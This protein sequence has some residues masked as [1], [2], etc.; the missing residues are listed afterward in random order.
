MSSATAEQLQREV[1]AEFGAQL[2]AWRSSY[3]GR[4]HE[5]LTR[6]WLL[7]LEREQIVTVAY[8]RDIIEA[9]L[10]HMP[11][12]EETRKV[13]ARAV[14]WAWRDEEM[15]A[16]YMRG[17]LLR[18]AVPTD[19]ARAWM[20]QVEGRIAGWTSSRQHHIRWAE[21]PA[22]RALAEALELAGVMA[23][24]IPGPARKALHFSTFSDFCCFNVAA[25]RTAGMGWARIAELAAEHPELGVA[26]D[27]ID[28]F[29]AIAADEERHAQ[30]F[31]IFA[32][33]FA[34][35]DRL[36]PGVDA[37]ALERELEGVGQRFVALPRRDAP[38]WRNPL[39]KGAPVL[40][41]Q[42]RGPGD[43]PRAL[44]AL[45]DAL[46]LPAD[47]TGQHVAI[48]TTFMM[49]TDRRDP[50]PGISVP[51]LKALGAWLHRRGAVVTVLD[52]ANIFDRYHARR[53]VAEVAAYLDL[54]S[55]HYAVVDADDVQVEHH[56]L[57]GLELHTIA[58]PWRDAHLRILLGK[59][60]GHPTS[61]AALTMEVAE[62]L[63][64]RNESRQFGDRR[65]D[66]ELVTAM[67]L[68]GF[69]P[70]L[71]LLDA[72]EH[73]PDGLM[74]V[75]GNATPK[76]P[77]RLYASRDAV[78]LDIVAG[79]HLGATDGALPLVEL[80]RDWFGDPSDRLTVDGPDTPIEGWTAPDATARTA[81]LSRLARPVY[82]HSSAHGALFL[83]DFDE[84][85]FPPLHR[86]SPGV[87]FARQLVRAVVAAPTSGA[88]LPTRWLPTAAGP[89]RIA[90]AGAG[91]PLVLLHGYP[92]TLQL[93]VN[94]HPALAAHFTVTAF[95]W[96]GQGYSARW[97]GAAA[98]LHR[99]LQLATI[100]DALGLNRPHLV[101]TDMG[102]HPALALAATQPHR[103]GRVAIMNALLFGD[104]PTSLEIGLMRRAGLNRL[105]FE[106]A[107]PLVYLQCKRTFLSP[108]DRR[109]WPTA[110][111]HDFERALSRPAVRTFLSDLCA[112][113]EAALPDLPALYWRLDTP[114]LALWA[115]RDAHFPVAQAERF[116]QLV[117]S[118]RLRVLAAAHHWMA[119]SRAADLA[120]HL[121]PFL[122]E[123]P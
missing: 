79:C 74:G 100:L 39:G 70:D 65:A 16:L 43:G 8:R 90:Q 120:Q 63:G 94:L 17:V 99:A 103:V 37:A 13:V 7:A 109:A 2:D 53:S 91:P 101:A 76:H 47:L 33:R 34:E 12:D 52:S 73:V 106:R 71:A 69:A 102:V 3:V 96:P 123:T 122:Q 21:S 83:P 44:T 84:A 27:D 35:D 114:L 108:H 36:V 1:I 115:E 93:F 40:V 117:P 121:I 11:V 61:G 49:V 45:L 57:R 60:R 97:P 14:R 111:D 29:A 50:S 85:A 66:R 24:K 110:L 118:T 48:M 89:V 5:E 119:H 23:G 59:L 51:L 42:T 6:L 20:A 28:A 77:H 54:D 64:G 81:L 56:Y 10:R 88:L 15:H 104:G 95:D 105:A 98:P 67:L 31:A 92:E 46:A 18:Q 107:A 112:D 9:R 72:T 22:T 62:G 55:P 30:V 58:A 80:C 19:Q 32:A 78:S 41:R 25:E 26:A 82:A 87:A 75:L 113:T 4:P 68:D 116:A 38:A 86:T